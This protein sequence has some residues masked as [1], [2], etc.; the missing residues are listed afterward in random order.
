MHEKREN[1]VIVEKKG[2]K[3]DEKE[4]SVVEKVKM[5]CRVKVE[6]S[7]SEKVAEQKEI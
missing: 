3:S 6:M 5:S 7:C 1:T 4:K 2:K